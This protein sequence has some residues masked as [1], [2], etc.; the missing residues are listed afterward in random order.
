MG[1]FFLGAGGGRWGISRIPPPSA[2]VVAAA[3]PGVILRKLKTSR[4]RS[5]QKMGSC[6]ARASAWNFAAVLFSYVKKIKRLTLK[7]MFF[8]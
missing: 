2:A 4:M 3:A 5:I 7:N 8:F 6:R 1:I